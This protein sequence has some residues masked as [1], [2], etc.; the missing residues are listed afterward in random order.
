MLSNRDRRINWLITAKGHHEA[1]RLVSKMG[2]LAGGT[3]P[4]RRSVTVAQLGRCRIHALHAVQASR[5]SGQNGTV[6]RCARNVGVVRGVRG[7]WC[8]WRLDT[9]CDRTFA[10]AIKGWHHVHVVCTYRSPVKVDRSVKQRSLVSQLSKALVLAFF[11]CVSKEFRVTST[12]SR[13]GT[14]CT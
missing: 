7:A 1:R 3:T 4:R 8:V 10:Y 9:I 6:A 14:V 5:V 11:A 13:I 2:R 12:A